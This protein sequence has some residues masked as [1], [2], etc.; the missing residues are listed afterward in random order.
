MRTHHH[1]KG[2]TQRF[3]WAVKQSLWSHWLL[4]ECKNKVYFLSKASVCSKN[5]C[6]FFGYYQ[7]VTAIRSLHG[8]H[9]LVC[10]DL[11]ITFRTIM[12]LRKKC[13]ASWK[14]KNVCL[15]SDWSLTA[16]TNTLQLLLWSEW[17]RCPVFITHSLTTVWWAVFKCLQT[18]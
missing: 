15:Q 9:Q 17:A 18:G 7:F 12:T 16:A 5:S 11:S 10:K 6:N 4:I 14:T 1:Q 13:S 8:K 3:R 2:H